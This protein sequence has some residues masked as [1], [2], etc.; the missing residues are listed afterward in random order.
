MILLDTQVLVWL[1]I[2]PERLSRAASSAVR[3]ARVSD[4]IAISAITLWELAMLF[5][6]NRIETYGTIETSVATIVESASVAI[7]PLTIAIAAMATQFPEEFPRDPADRIVAAT[8]RIE[9][10]SLI[11]RDERIRESSLLRTIW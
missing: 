4:G 7:K 6:R 5:A 3:R 11:T 10:L 9:G 2:E 1:V 8:A